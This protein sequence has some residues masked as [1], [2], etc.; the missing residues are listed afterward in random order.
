M[1]RTNAALLYHPDSF[2]IKR[3]ELKGRHVASAS[4][5]DGY[6]RHGG[7]EEIIGAVPDLSFREPFVASVTEYGAGRTGGPAPRADVIP[8]G[9]HARLGQIGT[10]FCAD[11]MLE[12]FAR[13][14][15]EAGHRSYS[16][17][18]ITHTISSKEVQAGLASY[19]T[20]PLQP[21]D[22]LICTSRA[23]RDVVEG[24]HQ[25]YAERLAAVQGARPKQQARLE[26]IPLGLDAAFYARHGADAEARATLRSRL[27]VAEDDILVLFLGRLAFH[28][29]AHPYPMYVAMQR[30]QERLKQDGRQLHFLMTG[31]FANKHVGPTFRDSAREA[32][33]D[34]PVHFLDGTPG[35]ESW[36]SWAA[37]DVFLSLSD[38]IQESFGITPIEAMAAGLPCV[39][40]DWDG[41]KDTVPDREVGFR[42]PTRMIPGGFGAGLAKSYADGATTYDRFIGTVCLMTQVDVDAAAQAIWRLA[43]SPDM[44]RRM[45]AA[46]RARAHTVYDW[47]AVVPRY[48]ELWTELAEIR[49]VAGD[50][51]P[52][53]SGPAPVLEDPTTVFAGFASQRFDGDTL[54]TAIRDPEAIGR[55]LANGMTNFT[56]GLVLDAQGCAALNDRIAAGASRLSDLTAAVPANDRARLLRTVI[57]LAKFGAVSLSP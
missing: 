13:R 43:T 54:V 6:V 47:S 21:W 42:V 27:G 48:Q 56:P 44:R 19:L 17:C 23:V 50:A 8:T 53:P 55:L 11:P 30:A 18:G 52:V 37:A 29:K 7:S 2:Q 14:R 40:S 36:A 26:T 33:P 15:S 51:P 49:A 34:V 25:R 32:C 5:L 24:L 38:N 31:Q 46:G 16:L 22:A 12:R 4:F 1:T 57:W 45:G 41:Y 35:P 3:N 20:M 39:V 28:A 9:D 10:L